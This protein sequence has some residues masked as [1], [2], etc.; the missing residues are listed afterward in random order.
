MTDSFDE[1]LIDLLSEIKV[2]RQKVRQVAR[3]RDGHPV[4]QGYIGKPE[5]TP[6]ARAH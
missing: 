5:R 3:S 1:Y 4:R 2:P 6:Q